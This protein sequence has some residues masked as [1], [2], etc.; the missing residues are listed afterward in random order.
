MFSELSLN[1]DRIGSS[2]RFRTIPCLMRMIRY[3]FTTVTPR[4]MTEAQSA[5]VES[6]NFGS[7][8][9]HAQWLF[10]EIAF[11]VATQAASVWRTCLPAEVPAILPKT[12]PETSPVPPG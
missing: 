11:P 4:A 7:D 10:P 3:V 1:L 2:V 5:N 12:E 6:I 8:R 9:G